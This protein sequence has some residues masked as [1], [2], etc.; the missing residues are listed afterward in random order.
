MNNDIIDFSRN[1]R[2]N[3]TDVE[4]KL[5]YELR[6]R[7]FL[8]LKFRRQFPI[9]K[10]IVDFCCFEKKLIIELD[11]GQHN[12]ITSL[13]YDEARTKFFKDEGYQV[14][15]FWNTDVVNNIEGVLESIKLK[16]EEEE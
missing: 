4:K 11:G 16:I 3:Q 14:L 8:G 5:W 1:L 9:D 12:E 6:N 15:R 2:Q 13:K 10:Y 7:R